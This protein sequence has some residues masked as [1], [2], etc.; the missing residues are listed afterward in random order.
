MVIWGGEWY[1]D[2]HAVQP[3]KIVVLDFIDLYDPIFIKI[4]EIIDLT[5]HSHA[6]PPHFRAILML[7][8]CP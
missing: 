7:H 8:W 5:S 2:L 3:L 1:N 4:T 6:K